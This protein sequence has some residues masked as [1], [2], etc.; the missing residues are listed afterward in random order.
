MKVHVSLDDRSYAEKPK[1]KEIIGVKRRCC[2]NWQE[3]ELRE[4]ADLVGNSGHAMVPGHMVGGM[5]S[6]KGKMP[7]ESVFMTLSVHDH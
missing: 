5:K 7:I 3:V 4:L 6:E 2:D 1:G